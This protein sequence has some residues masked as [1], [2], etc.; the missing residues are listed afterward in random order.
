MKQ[1]KQAIKNLRYQI[2][3][4]QAAL[5]PFSLRKENSHHFSSACVYLRLVKATRS[6]EIALCVL[7]AIEPISYLLIYYIHF[8][9]NGVSCNLIGSQEYDFSTNR[10][11][12]SANRAEIAPSFNQSH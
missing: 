11:P 10:T 3:V 1:P 12:S 4:F 9:I 2:L 7:P 5:S 8:E 6:E